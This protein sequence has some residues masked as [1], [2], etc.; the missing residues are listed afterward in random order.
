MSGHKTSPAPAPI[1]LSLSVFFHNRPY[2]PVMTFDL[3]LFA[4]NGDDLGQ[5]AF[6]Y[7]VQDHVAIANQL[8]GVV[9]AVMLGCPKNEPAIVSPI[10]GVS[11]DKRL[12]AEFGGQFPYREAETPV[13]FFL[14]PHPRFLSLSMG[15]FLA[16]DPRVVIKNDC[17][18]ICL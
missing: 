15:A 8:R 13:T 18:R 4:D 2:T 16:L 5:V 17:V 11:N 10:L 7:I 14:D 6:L 12:L 3:G 9:V 1:P